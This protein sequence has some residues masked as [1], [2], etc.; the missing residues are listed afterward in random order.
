M[1]KDKQIAD[2]EEEMA[3]DKEGC[4]DDM[5]EEEDYMQEPEVG[6]ESDEECELNERRD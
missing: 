4:L 6:V 1:N 2:A 3:K 5:E